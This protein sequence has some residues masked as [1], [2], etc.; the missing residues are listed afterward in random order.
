MVLLSFLILFIRPLAYSFCY[1]FGH[2]LTPSFVHLFTKLGSIVI[3]DVSK[4]CLAPSLTC[5]ITIWFRF[6]LCSLSVLNASVT[7]QRSTFWSPLV[8][9]CQTC[10]AKLRFIYHFQRSLSTA[11]PWNLVPTAYTQRFRYRFV[12]SVVHMLGSIINIA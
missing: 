1:L 5:I 12:E 8:D 10:Q 7:N 4:K 2:L 3:Q 11:L 6:F 9:R